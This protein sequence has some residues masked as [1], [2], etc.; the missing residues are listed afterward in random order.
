[1]N[2]LNI[3][4]FLQYKGAFLLANVNSLKRP[5]RAILAVDLTDIVEF[6]MNN[7][8]KLLYFLLPLELELLP[9]FFQLVKLL[10]GLV[11]QCLESSAL[12]NVAFESVGNALENL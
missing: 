4:F 9:L 5:I 12:F 10:F 1:M 7:T 6:L 8:L 2:F 11:Q 3:V